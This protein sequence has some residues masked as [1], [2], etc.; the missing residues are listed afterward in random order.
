MTITRVHH[1]TP[2]TAGWRYLSV[3][4]LRLDPGDTVEL[5]RPGQ[6]AALLS[7]HGAVTV[8]ADGLDARLAR[9]NP[10]AAM[11]DLLY[12]PPG[13]SVTI[14]AESASEIAIGA[15]PAAGRYPLRVI[16]AAEMASEL[17]GGG[18]ACRQIISP[19]ATP[20]PAESLIVYEAFVPRGAW[21]G[22]PPHRH[23]GEDG[24]PYLEET[25]YFHFDRPAGYGLHRNY[26]HDGYDQHAIVTDG[27]L[28]PVPRGYH[29]SAAA[30]AANMWILNFLAG[31]PEHRGQPPA[32]DLDEIWITTDWDH[33]RMTLPAVHSTNNPTEPSASESS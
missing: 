20:L 29:V 3:D 24:S 6:E 10:F 4:V 27:S 18:P 14:T 25:Y 21:A 15:A 12:T 11:G 22:W 1:L 13:T 26:A 7:V 33:G 17:R 5:H 19:L 28:V 30:P 16:R 2:E 31:A 9:A 32:F 8:R 23:D